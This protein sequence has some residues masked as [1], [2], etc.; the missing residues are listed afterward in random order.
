MGYAQTHRFAISLL[1][2]L[3][4]LHVGGDLR[5]AQEQEIHQGKLKLEGESITRLIL[6]REED[7]QREE[8]RRPEQ[9]IELPV[10]E[11]RVEEVHLKGGYICYAS[12]GLIRPVVMVGADEQATLKI[13]AP[14][15]QALEVK[16]QGRCLNM[17]Y[18]LLGAG[19]EEYSSGNTGGMPGFRVY[20]G[21]KE[22]ASGKFESG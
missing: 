4:F 13:G 8:F 9:V 19:G 17:D 18:T 21:D 10:G 12:R 11:Y 22:L 3:A 6:R 5:A 2:V 7:G 16:R 1:L 20:Q 15:R 14:L